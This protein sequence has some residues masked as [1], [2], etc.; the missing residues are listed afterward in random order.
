MTSDS[1]PRSDSDTSWSPLSDA[2][3]P[4]TL[5]PLPSLEL[6]DMD[7][8][9]LPVSSGVL[10][11]GALQSLD[12][13]VQAWRMPPVPGG[14]A[15]SLR[16]RDTVRP[17]PAQPEKVDGAQ[18]A[19]ARIHPEKA[20]PTVPESKERTHHSSTIEHPAPPTPWDIVLRACETTRA[21]G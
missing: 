16:R 12:A 5:S 13:Q 4:G 8:S 2:D 6:D 1:W 15:P 3:S 18:K 14:N 20:E 9:A 7:S 19:T 11:S 21:L 10:S 17:R